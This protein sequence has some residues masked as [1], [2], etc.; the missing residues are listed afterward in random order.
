MRVGWGEK[1]IRVG[2]DGV[3]LINRL[4]SVRGG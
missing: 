2:W 4:R 1:G 3:G